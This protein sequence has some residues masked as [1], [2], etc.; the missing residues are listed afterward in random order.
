M[1]W[2]PYD[3][4]F[5]LQVQRFWHNFAGFYMNGS[6]VWWRS[7][8]CNRSNCSCL[9]HQRFELRPR[10]CIFVKGILMRYIG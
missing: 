3:A 6:A 10:L 9:M 5:D 7:E 2:K 1:I 4:I 8:V